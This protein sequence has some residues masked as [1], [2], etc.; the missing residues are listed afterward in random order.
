MFLGMFG[1][2]KSSMVGIFT[3]QK[4]ADILKGQPVTQPP[5]SESLTHRLPSSLLTAVKVLLIIHITFYVICM[6]ITIG[7]VFTYLNFI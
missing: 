3:L 7:G 6:H 2:V 5:A 1:A 4:S